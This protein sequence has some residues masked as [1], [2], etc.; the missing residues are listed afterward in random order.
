MINFF[1]V[2]FP[3]SQLNLSGPENNDLCFSACASSHEFQLH[4]QPSLQNLSVFLQKFTFLLDEAQ[5]RS[6]NQHLFNIQVSVLTRWS[7]KYLYFS[8][9]YFIQL[10]FSTMFPGKQ[11]AAQS[12]QH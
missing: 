3:P 9:N 5:M 8:E 12:K 11:T 2:F 7:I 4:K 1:S 10:S 6:T